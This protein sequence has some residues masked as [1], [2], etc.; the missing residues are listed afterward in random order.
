MNDHTALWKRLLTGP[1]GPAILA[2][3]MEH[4]ARGLSRMVGQ[5][6]QNDPPQVRRM[7]FAQVAAC[8]G[9]PETP[10]VGVYLTIAS[11]LIGWALL[12]IPLDMAL[13]VTDGVRAAPGTA[14][15]LTRLEKSALA[16]M[17]NLALSYFLNAVAERCG[18]TEALLPSPP[19]VI[20]DM[21]GVIL[22]LMVTATPEAEELWVIETIFRD[23]TQTVQICFWAAPDLAGISLDGER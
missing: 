20:V 23:T 11:G 10:T 16:E 12:S 1:D 5:A 19:A 13:W 22:N 15:R 8:V 4:V 2:A 18:G 14:T 17:G 6:V 7:S 3:A 21:L 9:D